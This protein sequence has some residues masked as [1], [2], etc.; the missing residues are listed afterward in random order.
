MSLPFLIFAIT[1]MRV[2]GSP[3]MIVVSAFMVLAGVVG[4]AISLATQSATRK[5]ASFSASPDQPGLG[6]SQV[7]TPW[8]QPPGSPS[9]SWTPAGPGSEQIQEGYSAR[10]ASGGPDQSWTHLSDD[11]FRDSGGLPDARPQG[12]SNTPG[13]QIRAGIFLILFALV[14]GGIVPVLSFFMR[15]EPSQTAEVAARVTS[16]REYRDSDDDLT[17][18]F[19]Y[20]FTVDGQV[21]TGR[22]E[23]SLSSYCHLNNGSSVAVRYDPTGPQHNSHIADHSA[24]R[25]VIPL[26]LLFALIPAFGGV[27]SIVAGVRSRRQPR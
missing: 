8:A 1:Y 19:R 12:K 11:Q 23:S 17:C 21:Y 20:E 24:F 5:Y 27:Q 6:S 13:R 7:F 2:L 15:A 14:F 22:S 26:L 18:S 3:L 4:L 25:I 16:V 9:Q 10:P